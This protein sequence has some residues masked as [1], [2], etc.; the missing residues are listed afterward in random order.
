MGGRARGA[1][2]SAGGATLGGS[3]TDTTT[4]G[5]STGAGR[6]AIILDAPKRTSSSPHLPEMD[7]VVSARSGSPSVWHFAQWQSEWSLGQWQRCVSGATRATHAGSAMR[8]RRK[9]W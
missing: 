4:L 3:A 2:A 6:T 9:C 8:K 7:S 5:T 1:P